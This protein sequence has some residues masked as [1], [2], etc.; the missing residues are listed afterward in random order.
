M[1][2][3]IPRHSVQE[4][5]TPCALILGDITLDIVAGV[6][7]ADELVGL[8][9]GHDVTFS[10]KVDSLLGG[11]AWLFARAIAAHSDLEPRILASV[12]HDPAGGMLVELLRQRGM[13][14]EGI[15]AVETARTAV[16][17]A[18]F[19]RGGGRLMLRNADS[20]SRRLS[21]KSV[22]GVL[23]TLEPRMVRL[24]FISG[25]V[26]ARPGAP[27]VGAAT[28]LVRWSRANGVPVVLDLVPHEF[29]ESVGTVR[30]VEDVLGPID[31]LVAE[32][33][34]ARGLGF[35]A[36]FSGESLEEVMATVANA[37]ATG[38]DMAVVQ[39]RLSPTQYGQ[40]FSRGHMVS[41]CHETIGDNVE[42][43]GL[44]DIMLVK[45][46]ERSGF[47]Q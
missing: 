41:A 13:T 24:C 32:L 22:R 29:A 30:E 28:E 11:T 26:L 7:S 8:V 16:D 25:Y 1:V 5:T 3:R 35:D 15:S 44:G 6:E 18:V 45:A 27:S 10:T 33:R 17:V 43:L 38:R 34:T 2:G 4:L 19:P 37:L 20:A 31:V 12:G 40:V 46:L 39:H 14:T 21:R 36:S 47:L 42:L 23:S 9:E